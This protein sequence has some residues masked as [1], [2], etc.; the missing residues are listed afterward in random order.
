MTNHKNGHFDGNIMKEHREAAG[1]TQLDL[2][3]YL[4]LSAS[5]IN[6]LE[7]G[8]RFPSNKSLQKIENFIRRSPDDLAFGAAIARARTAANLT[9][10]D[11]ARLLG[12]STATVYAWERGENFCNPKRRRQ[13]AAALAYVDRDTEEKPAEVPAEEPT[14]APEEPVEVEE[15]AKAKV[16]AVDRL[17]VLFAARA[18]NMI[19]ANPEI[20]REEFAYKYARWSAQN[21]CDVFEIA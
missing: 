21:I 1:F 7:Q 15:P 20:T 19:A 5:F 4:D 12:V 16:S 14:E 17:T 9:G 3:K 13:I 2:A 10:K 18:L 6:E 11:L 8:H